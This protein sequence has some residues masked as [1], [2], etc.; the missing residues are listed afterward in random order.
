[1]ASMMQRWPIGFAAALLSV[2]WNS[3]RGHI[4]DSHLSHDLVR[5]RRHFPNIREADTL[6]H[7]SHVAVGCVG[8]RLLYHDLIA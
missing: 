5:Y 6:S 3:P 1:M 7:M 2:E 8:H 4:G